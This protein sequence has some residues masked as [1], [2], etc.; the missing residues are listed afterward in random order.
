MWSSHS[1]LTV[2]SNRLISDAIT[3]MKNNTSLGLNLVLRYS[4]DLFA[5]NQEVFFRRKTTIER[6]NASRR[7]RNLNYDVEK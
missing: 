4:N 3:D 5:S 1:Q 2:N 7:F 6:L